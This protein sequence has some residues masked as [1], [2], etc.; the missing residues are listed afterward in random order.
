MKK[1]FLVCL[2]LSSMT[3][4]SAQDP[5]RHTIDSMQYKIRDFRDSIR[6]EIRAYKD[7]IQ[8]IRRHAY[9]SIP[10]ELRIGW[11][12]Q[13]FETLVWREVGYPVGIPS[14]YQGIYQE[15]FRYTQHWFA[16]YMYNVNY[17]YGIGMLFDYSGVLWDNVT[18]NGEGKVMNTVDNRCF[19]NI[20]IMPVIRFSYMH[21]EYISL[22]SALG[23]GLNLNTGTEIDYKGRTT[24]LAPVMNIS[25]L[26]LRVGKGRWYGIMELGG[27]LSL[28][29]TNEIYMF[30]SRIF[31]ASVGCR[32]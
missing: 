32:L 19:H 5:M 2:L 6:Y 9:D 18:R 14:T 28:V 1:T 12:D 29:D 3:W 27:M 8:N 23:I 10:H 17:W 24:A 20:S 11:G 15:N 16:E 21:T 31:T 4:I 30:G 25:L 22:Y 26:G 13:M 7:S